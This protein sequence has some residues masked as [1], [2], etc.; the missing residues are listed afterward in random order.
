MSTKSVG[1]GDLR[2]VSVER[3]L[4]SRE[5]LAPLFSAGMQSRI[6]G[7]ALGTGHESC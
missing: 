7:A 1:G 3:D 4:E 2:A 5:R 6:L